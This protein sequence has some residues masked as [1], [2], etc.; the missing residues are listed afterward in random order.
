M[1]GIS[2]ARRKITGAEQQSGPMQTTP[3]PDQSR[4]SRR[5]GHETSIF[6]LRQQNPTQA[7]AI[8]LKQQQ[9]DRATQCKAFETATGLANNRIEEP[10]LH[11]K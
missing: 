8:Q 1:G 2:A 7:K 9:S 10:V 5:Y 4:C 6:A 11:S 3:Q